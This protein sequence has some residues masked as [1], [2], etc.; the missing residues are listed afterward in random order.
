M[1]D[2]YTQQS[3]VSWDTAA[4]NALAYFALRPQLIWDQFAEVRPTAQTHTGVSVTFTFAGDMTAATTALTETAD[5]DAVALS[6]STV[7][8]TL[9][10]YG[11]AVLTSAE[12]RLTSY[13]EV[14]PIVANVVGYNAGISIDTVARNNIEDGTNVR[15]ATGGATDPTSRTTIN[16]DDSVTGDDVR[17]CVAKLRGNS[18]MPF[19]SGYAGVIHPDVSYDF[20]GATGGSNWRDPHT[21]S[22]P[23]GIF[24]GEIGMFEGV[25]FIES[26]RACLFVDASNNAG[27]AGTIDVYGTIIMGQQAFA[28]AFA[29]REGYGPNPQVILGPITDKLRRFV[30]VGWKHFVGYDIFRQAALYRIESASTIG[31][32]A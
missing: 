5:V 27:A 10:E 9:A 28:K 21:Y 6:D 2:A 3:S 30:P 22:S 4:Y 11:N 17:Y 12:L 25:R 1:A 19:G 15:Y 8:V 16:T 20:R 13:V 23:E 32:N 7:T 14:D 26:P 31:T 29:S 24:T 18:A